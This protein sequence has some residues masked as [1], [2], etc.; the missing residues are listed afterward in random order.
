MFVKGPVAQWI[1]RL[2]SDQAVAGSSPA[3]VVPFPWPNWIRHLTTNQG[4][5]GS[6]PARNVFF[7][8]MDLN[9][10]FFDFLASIEYIQPL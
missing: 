9:V 8:N 1:A 2:T 6:S 4:T 5:A 7:C 10:Y 3:W